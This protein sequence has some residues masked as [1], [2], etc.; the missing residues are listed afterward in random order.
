[1]TKHSTHN[2][3]KAKAARRAAVIPE[4][5]LPDSWKK[6]E[7]EICDRVRHT[8]TMFSVAPRG[9]VIRRYLRGLEVMYDVI[10][11]GPVAT[12]YHCPSRVLLPD[13]PE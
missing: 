9:R 2:R 12:V 6:P 10:W 7:F 3:F 8:P 13:T 4:T 1:M 5:G 11:N